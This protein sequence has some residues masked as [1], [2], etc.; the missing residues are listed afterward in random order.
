MHARV[1][2]NILGKRMVDERKNPTEPFMLNEKVIYLVWS[3]SGCA[4]EQSRSNQFHRSCNDVETTSKEPLRIR[5]PK[6]DIMIKEESTFSSL[7]FFSS[8]ATHECTRS[9]A[10]F[11]LPNLNLDT[12]RSAFLLTVL[13]LHIDS[14]AAAQKWIKFCQ[15]E[16]NNSTTFINPNRNDF[17]SKSSHAIGGRSARILFFYLHMENEEWWKKHDKCFVIS[18]IFSIL[19]SSCVLWCVESFCHWMDKQMVH[20]KSL[21][22]S[23]ILFHPIM[24]MNRFSCDKMYV[25]TSERQ[26]IDWIPNFVIHQQLLCGVSFAVCPNF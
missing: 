10:I 12:Q 16:K 18:F 14:F 24:W 15:S 26:T 20:V 17:A 1:V 2:E 21:V 6:T 5:L 19:S 13:F 4:M 3:T 7:C 22:N 23:I 9:K 11:T 8:H 25:R